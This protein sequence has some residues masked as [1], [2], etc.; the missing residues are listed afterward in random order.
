M[1]EHSQLA[2]MLLSLFKSTELR[3]FVR[4]RYGASVGRILE[5]KG[6]GSTQIAGLADELIDRQLVDDAFFDAV[7][8]R[9]P[10]DSELIERVRAHYV[11]VAPK[12]AEDE[13]SISA[14]EH[15]G[16]DEQGEP[17]SEPRREWRSRMESAFQKYSAARV[18]KPMHWI[19]AVAVLPDFEPATIQPFDSH[20]TQPVADGVVRLASYCHSRTDGRWE[21]HLSERR[22]ALS[23]LWGAGDIV[24][25][26]DANHHETSLH[27]SILRRLT[28]QAPI[29]IRE[30]GEHEALLAARDISDWFK[31]IDVELFDLDRLYAVLERHERVAPLRALVGKHFCG[32]QKEL[33]RLR[34]HADPTSSD[35]SILT[36]W[37][38]GGTGKSTVLGKFLL[39][40]E[41]ETDPPRPWAYLDFDDPGIDPTDSYRLIELIARHIG[42]LYAGTD[43]N[44]DT[45][46]VALESVAAGDFG[47]SSE[48]RFDGDGA[49]GER[50]LVGRLAEAIRGLPMDPSLLLVFDTFEQ[51]QV[52][53]H[54]AVQQ[55]RDLIDTIL[56]AMP[57]ARIIASGRADVKQWTDREVLGLEDLDAESA[58]AVLRALGLS[59][60]T[61]RATIIARIGTNPLSIRIVADG[62]KAGRLSTQ[63]LNQLVMGA[64]ALELQG[65]LYTRIL[66]HI[67]DGE[68]RRLAHPGLVVRR[69]TKDVIANVLAEICHIKPERVE[70]LFRKLPNHVALFESDEAAPEEGEALRHRQDLREI[71]LKLMIEDPKWRGRLMEIHSRAIAHYKNIDH[72][73]ARAEE[74]YHRLMRDDES[75]ILD[76][77]WSTEL[78]ASLSRS[79]GEPFPERAELWLG[80]RLGQLQADSSEKWRLAD[81]EVTIAREA[82]SHLASGD[83]KGA[84]ELV[85]ETTERSPGSKLY[86]IESRAL[87]KLK[88][89]DAAI[90]VSKRGLDAVSE[91]SYPRVVLDLNQLAAQILYEQKRYDAMERYCEAAIRIASA[92]ND[93]AAHLSMFELRVRASRERGDSEEP[94]DSAGQLERMFVDANEDELLNARVV[95]GK[96]VSTLG[97]SSKKVLRKAALTF[98]NRAQQDVV[99]PDAF[100]LEKLLGRADDTEGGKSDLSQLAIQVGLP[101]KNYELINLAGAAIRYGR[102]GDAMAVVLDHVGNEE[103]VRQD[104]LSMFNVSE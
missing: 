80:P 30:I 35:P 95:S 39:D 97:A 58:D 4:K 92:L 55:T 68:V 90:D 94:G 51:V 42:L 77:I 15:V 43:Q 1:Q 56:E 37:G 16:D 9:K 60:T 89:L 64:R 26:L 96:V 100:I 11:P 18:E 75:A 45:E 69:L 83:A 53:G 99:R 85:R 22:E 24:N 93:T 86:A 61:V 98:G 34:S 13:Q 48:F 82:E 57:F 66:G 12:S 38:A 104:T 63:D 49:L 47:Q 54:H 27:A 91:T 71:M 74:L 76:G 7:L 88:K 20:G 52:R 21:L 102:M 23:R 2:S 36:L 84:L 73:I 79:W 62:L 32:R 5:T 33:R 81:R 6:S 29:P 50:E 10:D 17:M 31:R 72:P 14:P 78:S 103:D 28:K 25:A 40:Y 44:S 65:Q 87:L 70:E 59:D 101:S 46:F 67:P 3:R 8:E 19:D 41:G